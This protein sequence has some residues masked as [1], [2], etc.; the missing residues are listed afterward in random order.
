MAHPQS[1]YSSTGIWKCLFLWREENLSTQR[2]TL[3][4]GTRTNNKLNPHMLSTPRTEPGLHWLEASVLTTTPPLLHK[5][6]TVFQIKPGTNDNS[7]VCT[8]R[9][10]SLNPCDFYLPWLCC[11]I[12]SLLTNTFKSLWCVHADLCFQVTVVSSIQALILQ[13]T[14]SGGPHTGCI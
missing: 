4:E 5:R 12:V 2:K 14:Q 10:Y 11:V 13:G 8:V 6:N 7:K 3:G 9:Y 1:S